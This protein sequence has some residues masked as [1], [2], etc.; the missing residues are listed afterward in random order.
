MVAG[1][2]FVRALQC[3]PIR[4]NTPCYLIYFA[5]WQNLYLI[6]LPVHA[7][8]VTYYIVTHKPSNCALCLS[9]LSDTQWLP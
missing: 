1:S 8:S 3:L 6:P 2:K 5:Q 4:S 9:L 7:A